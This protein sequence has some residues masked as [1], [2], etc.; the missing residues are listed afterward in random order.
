MIVKDHAFWHRELEEPAL[1]ILA[2]TQ[3]ASHLLGTDAPVDTPGNLGAD[4]ASA[5]PA[6]IKRKRDDNVRHHLIGEDGLLT[7]NG[8]GAELCRGFQKGECL[9]RDRN[10]FCIKTGRTR[11]QCTKCLSE[12]HGA[13]ACPQSGRAKR[14][15]QKQGLRWGR[16]LPT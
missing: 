3:K 12:D 14:G 5:P 4:R 16:E 11:H 7:H 2:K 9:E 8:R 10:G 13:H 1:L 6:A 15:R